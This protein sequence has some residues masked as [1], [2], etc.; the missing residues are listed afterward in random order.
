[1]KLFDF[2]T[3]LRDPSL[4]PYNH[5]LVILKEKTRAC[6]GFRL[7]NPLR[8][9]QQSMVPT[10]AKVLYWEGFRQTVYVINIHLHN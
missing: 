6:E 10:T 8:L 4:P 5:C 9:P 2:L 3:T 7:K 1:M